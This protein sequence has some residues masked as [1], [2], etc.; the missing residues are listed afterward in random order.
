MDPKIWEYIRNNDAA[1]M[2]TLYQ[3]CYQELYVFGFRLVADKEKVKDCL[4]EIFCEIWLKRNQIGEIQN[5]KAYL[6]TC[7]KNKLLQVIKQ[8]QKSEP[9]ND[10][11]FLHLTENSYEQLLIATETAADGKI[12]LWKAINALTPTQ[13]EIIK[14]KYFEE[15]SYEAISIMLKLKPR[16]V[17]NHVHS[18][19]CML[20]AQLKN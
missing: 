7:I 11:D 15:L 19:I 18:A 6:K 5:I 16:T 4:H 8:D 17:Y 2:K 13:K 3:S 20:R 1:A 14:L 9:F 12:K 10:Q